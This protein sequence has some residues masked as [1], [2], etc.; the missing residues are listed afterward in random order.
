VSD[1]AISHHLLLPSESAIRRGRSS[2]STQSLDK[3]PAPVRRELLCRPLATSDIQIRQNLN[4]GYAF[5][6]N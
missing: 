3:V 1:I 5:V 2:G 4:L 6:T